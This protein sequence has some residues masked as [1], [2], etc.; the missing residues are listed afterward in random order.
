MTD[1]EQR[2]AAH[3]DSWSDGLD[4]VN[5]PV[6]GL[7]KSAKRRQFRR[8]RTA[9]AASSVMLSRRLGSR[10]L[11]PGLR[12]SRPWSALGQCH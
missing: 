8:R 6:G 7:I 11:V 2:L 5:A 3:L 1:L 10:R 12:K 4:V 9:V